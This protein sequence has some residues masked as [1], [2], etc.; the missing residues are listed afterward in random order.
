MQGTPD[1]VYREATRLV[2][3]G[4]ANGG[5]QI[6]CTGC[7]LPPITPLENILAMVRAAEDAYA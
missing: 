2:E 3:L 5:G 7:E 1:D 4:K 6:V